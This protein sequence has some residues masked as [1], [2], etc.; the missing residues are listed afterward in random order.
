[1][2]EVGQNVTT[3]GAEMKRRGIMVGRQFSPLDTMCRITVGTDEDMARFREAF[4]ELR[5]A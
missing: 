2:V 3:F 1:M 4:R 5:S